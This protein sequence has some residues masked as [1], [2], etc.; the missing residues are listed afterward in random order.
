M[1]LLLLCIHESIFFLPGNV[2]RDF[3]P[4]V[5]SPHLQVYE[6][7]SLNIQEAEETDSG[8]Y[9]CQASNIV[10]TI[11]KVVKVTVHGTNDWSILDLF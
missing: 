1:K 6:N 2:P 9:L 5:S 7:G 10:G 4:I 3:K 11:S 8:Y